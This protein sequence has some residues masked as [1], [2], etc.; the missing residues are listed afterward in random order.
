MRSR[1]SYRSGYECDEI[2]GVSHK[3]IA[4]K[5]KMNERTLVFKNKGN[6]I[7]LMDLIV[8]LE[9]RVDYV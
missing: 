1:N 9:N 8:T 2:F 6:N 3:K 5:A 4:D 7:D